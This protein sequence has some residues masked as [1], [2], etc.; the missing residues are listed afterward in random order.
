MKLKQ[1]R[2]MTALILIMMVAA[3]S[4]CGNNTGTD[5]TSQSNGWQ[6]GK[7]VKWS[8]DAIKAS[9]LYPAG[10][11]VS[12]IQEDEYA[13]YIEISGGAA[14]A[15]T[16]FINNTSPTDVSRFKA[17]MEQHFNNKSETEEGYQEYSRKF[18]EVD[19]YPAAVLDYKGITRGQE[20][21]EM[22][23]NTAK[24]NLDYQFS[25]SF[26]M[27]SDDAR[28]QAAATEIINSFHLMKGMANFAAFHVRENGKMAKWS[29]NDL[30]ASFLY[31]EGDK[32]SVKNGEVLIDG[33]GSRISLN[34]S[35][36]EHITDSAMFKATLE[37]ELNNLPKDQ[38][39]QE[40]SH[41][42]YEVDGYPAGVM[43]YK[44]IEQNEDCHYMVLA[45]LKDGC[46]YSLRV[47]FSSVDDTK[48]K[49]KAAKIISS[50]HLM[51]GEPKLDALNGK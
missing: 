7:L 11:K 27:G 4:G 9:F 33:V 42:F 30:K 3:L 36:D 46:I 51:K 48:Y 28:N 17:N 13:V 50:F 15:I 10:S 49:I 45:V 8:N 21:H 23:L 19:G 14:T 43:D 44:I 26:L 12:I 2:A 37:E 16:L 41:K 32:I 6:S 35:E 25:I 29:N 5:A 20:T 22:E 18:Y 31:P 34:V 40:Y 24:G 1:I 39:F 47:S 38:G